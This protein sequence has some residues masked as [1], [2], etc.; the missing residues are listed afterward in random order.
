MP[1]IYIYDIYDIT[2]RTHLSSLYKKIDSVML[3]HT[4]SIEFL[5]CTV[6]V[7]KVWATVK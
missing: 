2:V 1:A 5:R 7:A 6:Y 3:D 4:L